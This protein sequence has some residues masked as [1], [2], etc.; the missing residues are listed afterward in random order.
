[1]GIRIMTEFTLPKS[2]APKTVFMFADQTAQCAALDLQKRFAAAE[3]QSGNAQAL[4]GG[5]ES[6]LLGRPN[7]PMFEKIPVALCMKRAWRDATQ[8]E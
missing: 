2:L 5:G 4:G 8:K 6:E 3:P 1:M 7:V